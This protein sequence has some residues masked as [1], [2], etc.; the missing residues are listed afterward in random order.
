M[1]EEVGQQ[2]ILVAL[3]ALITDEI[4]DKC[5]KVGFTEILESPLY[6]KKVEEIIKQV[7][8]DRQVQFDLEKL[9][10]KQQELFEGDKSLSC[11]E[12]PS[13]KIPVTR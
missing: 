11:D 3:S 2:P 12:N 10:S 6:S 8:I 9:I 5:V 7:R 1:F 13:L 4:R